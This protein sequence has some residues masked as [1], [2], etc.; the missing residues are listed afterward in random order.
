MC[1]TKLVY[2]VTEAPLSAFPSGFVG[3]KQI[4]AS[5]TYVPMRA[6]ITALARR[7]DR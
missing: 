1:A 6:I 4:G 5:F 7:H 3:A 2:Q